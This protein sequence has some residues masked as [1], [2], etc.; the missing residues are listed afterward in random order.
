[1]YY[2]QDFGQFQ[3]QHYEYSFVICFSAYYCGVQCGACFW[4]Y[5]FVLQF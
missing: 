5:E 4:F 3:V 2:L 1:M